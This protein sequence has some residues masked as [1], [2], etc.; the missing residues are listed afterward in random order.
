MG[1]TEKKRETTIMRYVR[2][3][4]FMAYKTRLSSLLLPTSLGVIGYYRLVRT[5]AFDDKFNNSPRPRDQSTPPENCLAMQRRKPTLT[6]FRIAAN[7]KGPCTQE[8]KLS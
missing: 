1:I 7:P 8:L 6:S 4:G 5:G 3:I 2:S